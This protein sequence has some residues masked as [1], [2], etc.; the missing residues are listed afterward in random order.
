M[1]LLAL[2]LAH[3][4][5]VLAASSAD[6]TTV[7]TWSWKA[8][9]VTRWHLETE[10]FTPRGFV[11]AYVDPKGAATDAT[12]GRVK[13]VVDTECTASLEGKNTVQDCTFAYVNLTGDPWA[14]P[15]DEKLPQVL[16]GMSDQL[17]T[18]KVE[19]VLGA[20]GRIRT[21]DLQGPKRTNTF[22]AEVIEVERMVLQRA[23][24][25][26]D[27]PLPATTDDIKRGWKQAS[28]SALMILPTTSGT[29]GAYELR[30]TTGPVSDNLLPINTYGVGKLSA[31]SAVDAATGTR[32]VDT[33]LTSQAVFDLTL[34]RLVWRGF[35]IDGR[36]TVASNN[37][38]T[39][40]EFYQSTAMQMVESF[41]P[42]GAAPISLMAS[43]APRRDLP[44]PELTT[45]L[46]LVEFATLGMQP[47]FIP[48]MPVAGKQLGLPTTSVTAR[49][50]VDKDG[51]VTAASVYKGY[52]AL[53]DACEIALRSARFAK[54]GT[55][56]AV[57]VNVE[58]RA[59][60]AK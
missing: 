30:Y 55:P 53:A 51:K 17:K 27:L 36:L 5:P 10:I 47:L 3:A 48:A 57:D 13:V 18:A 60:A 38:G 8:G 39:D 16:A 9:E 58:F 45:G 20:D 2:L 7:P 11:F 4:G 31:G 59:E 6:L 40:V 41:L 43:R 15:A 56:Y 52:E 33:T 22:S 1:P 32:I 26:F 25:G 46:A 49:V 44:T 21:F 28:T 23:F 14:L 12:A 54:T 34:S 24:C 37:A 19:M 50:E 42:D 35:T 29:T